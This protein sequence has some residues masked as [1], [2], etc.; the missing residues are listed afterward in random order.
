[1]MAFVGS[2]SQAVDQWSLAGVTAG[3]TGLRLQLPVRVESITLR[4]DV[5]AQPRISRVWLRPTDVH[6]PADGR[7]VAIRAAHYGPV[8]TFFLDEWSY[9][10]PHGFWTRGGSVTRVFFMPDAGDSAAVDVQ[11]G[12]LAN[13]V[14][15]A[16]GSWSARLDLSPGERR[17][18]QVPAG[19]VT[20]RTAGTF[21]PVDYDPSARDRRPLGVRIEV[22]G[23]P[24]DR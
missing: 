6:A 8:R 22:P 1:L 3:D 11:T 10:E 17:R 21:R 14:E 19:I 18:V 23:A 13:T 20:L 16:G 15:I 5:V 12:P 4:A 24:H 2:T 9:V 7:L